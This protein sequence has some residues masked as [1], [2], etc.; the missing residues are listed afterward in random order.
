[1]KNQ[2]FAEI[3][4]IE[5]GRNKMKINIDSY[6]VRADIRTMSNFNL[7]CKYGKS[8]DSLKELI[9]DGIRRDMLVSSIDELSIDEF[10][11]LNHLQIKLSNF[12]FI[13]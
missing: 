3:I 7:K 1:M 4:N 10:L 2:T 11:E 12:N 6:Q 5:E 13:K 8:K 9:K